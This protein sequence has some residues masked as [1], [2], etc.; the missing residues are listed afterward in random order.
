MTDD[1]RAVRHI[2]SAVGER[3]NSSE[4]S[5]V[6]EFPDQPQGDL[7]RRGEIERALQRLISSATPGDEL[8]SLIETV[9][10]NMKAADIANHLQGADAQAFVDV[11]DQA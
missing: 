3:A 2:E 1:I 4:S 8:P 10:S 9:V 11:L 6:P 5:A 7:K